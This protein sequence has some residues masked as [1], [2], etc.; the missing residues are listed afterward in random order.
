MEETA[1]FRYNVPLDL[2]DDAVQQRDRSLT[3]ERYMSRALE[4]A[5][6]GVG[7]TSPNPAV[8]CVI[9]R[10]GR[11]VG[12][13]WHE[14]AGEPHAEVHA[15]REAGEAA[16]G[17]TLYVTLEPCSHTGRTGPCAEAV[18]QAGVAEVVVAV[19]DPNPRVSGRGIALLEKAGARVRVGV[20]EDEAS[21]LNEA[22]FC[23]I[24]TGRP[25]LHMKLAM[26]LDGRSATASGESQWITGP[27]ARRLVHRM[28]AESDAVLVG[29]A[30]LRADDPSLT[31]RDYLRDD[32]RPVRQPMRI[33]VTNEPVDTGRKLFAD[34]AER[35]VLFGRDPGE[36]HRADL[37][38]RGVGVD[39]FEGEGG[40][41]W[42][43]ALQA[44]G[45]RELR[46]VLI[47]PGAVL[48]GELVRRRLVQR[49]TAFVSPQLM[50]GV[51]SR[52]A[53]GGPDPI[54]LADALRLQNVECERVGEDFRITGRV[55]EENGCLPA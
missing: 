51:H 52:P 20:L 22:F 25:F 41:D 46:S 49:V 35:L 53:V 2:Y 26:T 7:T 18:A 6:R 19:R 9:V 10:D 23:A 36:R 48:A 1:C 16:R 17:A 30:T 40:L 12:E 13:G 45:K 24:A 14:R 32:G 15:L 3:D 43:A 54:R 28:R 42:N 39:V 21:R 4:L 44:L 38:D 8:G 29:G 5:S 33:V 55:P 31:V 11:V 37:A 47:E 50:G 34:G 27:E